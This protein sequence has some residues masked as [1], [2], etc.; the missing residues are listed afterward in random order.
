MQL[1][2][3]ITSAIHTGALSTSRSGLFSSIRKGGC[4]DLRVGVDVVGEKVLFD[5]A[6]KRT[7]VA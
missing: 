7:P 1:H 3:F 5:P 2:T 4:M 6:A